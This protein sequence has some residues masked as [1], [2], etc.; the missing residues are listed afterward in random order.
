MTFLPRDPDQA[1]QA[2]SLLA[3]AMTER[4]LIVRGWREVPVDPAV[5]GRIAAETQPAI[6]QL[7]VDAPPAALRRS[8]SAT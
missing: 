8:S 7:L 2:K 3:Q 5:L 1:D 4:G 6:A